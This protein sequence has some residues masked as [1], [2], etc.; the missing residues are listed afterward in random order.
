[1]RALLLW[2]CLALGQWGCSSSTG[3]PPAPA[4]DSGL[5][6]GDSVA[7]D[8]DDS[9]GSGDDDSAE[10]EDRYGSLSGDCGVLDSLEIASGLSRLFRNLIDFGDSPFDEDLLGEGAQEVISDG[11]LGGNSLH[12]EAISFEV[13]ERCE[14]AVLLKTEAEIDYVDSA[15]KKTDLL[16]EVAGEKLGVSVTR[17]FHFPPGEPYTEAEATALLEDKLADVL[18]SSA[19][20]AMSDAWSRAVLHVIAYDGSHGDTI[21]VAFDGLASTVIEDTLLVLTVTDGEDQY[22]Y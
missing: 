17:A 8:D 7:A 5:G 18:L 3:E 11:N 2:L 6:G 12:S 14:S 10:D 20:V 15:G 13:L 21:E 16:V 22:L 1:M 4:V 9:G 19:N